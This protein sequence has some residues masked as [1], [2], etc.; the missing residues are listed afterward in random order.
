MGKWNGRFR[1]L[2]SC[3]V[4]YGPQMVTTAREVSLSR[5]VLPT[6]WLSH[7]VPAAWC[8]WRKT[9]RWWEGR[10]ESCWTRWRESEF[11]LFSTK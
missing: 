6:V 1:G 11:L 7:T 2:S 3:P 8:V 5:D 4:H 9:G 10:L